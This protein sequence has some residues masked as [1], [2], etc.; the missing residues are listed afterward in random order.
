M[1]IRKWKL[2]NRILMA[3]SKLKNCKRDSTH[4]TRNFEPGTRNNIEH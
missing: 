4:R 3:E 1:E 2:E